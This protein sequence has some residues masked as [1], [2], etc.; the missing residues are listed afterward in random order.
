MGLFSAVSTTK[1]AHCPRAYLAPHATL[2][3]IPDPALTLGLW[4]LALTAMAH[5]SHEYPYVVFAFIINL[6]PFNKS[7]GIGSLVAS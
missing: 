4:R 3:L 1:K 2:Y 6:G 5:F 7:M